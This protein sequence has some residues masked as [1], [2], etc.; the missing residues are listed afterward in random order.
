MR[1]RNQGF[2]RVGERITWQHYV[3]DVDVQSPPSQNR[4]QRG[5]Q[6][7]CDVGQRDFVARDHVQVH[8]VRVD[9]DPGNSSTGQVGL[10]RPGKRCHCRAGRDNAFDQ[11]DVEGCRSL[12]GGGSR[13]GSG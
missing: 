3:F 2:V 8:P 11:V 13:T 12:P 7:I 5:S 10:M 1:C 6:L 4:L 9:T